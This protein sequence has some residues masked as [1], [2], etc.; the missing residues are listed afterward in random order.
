MNHKKLIIYEYDSLFNILNEIKENL[1]FVPIKANKNN[2]K[3]IKSDLT[4]DFI[5]I[6]KK[7]LEKTE[8]EIILQDLPY[9]LN[10][11]IELI[12]IH[13]LKNK[14][15]LQSNVIIGSYHL[16]L[17]SR[18][19]VRNNLHLNLT[20]RETNLIVYLNKSKHPVKINEL[21]K[22]VWEYVSEL[23]THTVETHIYRLRKKI[24]EK[25]GD[26]D[27]ILSLKEG[28]KIN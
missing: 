10:K 15:N 11:L 20:E 4:S 5:V 23:E 25:F 8:N 21:Q 3:N 18:K 28:Y 26:E 6:S 14:F 7:K 1:N 22:N 16:N 2:I 27:F 24:K 9:K 19:I 17:N 12:N 13:F